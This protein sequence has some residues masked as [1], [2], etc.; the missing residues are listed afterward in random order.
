MLMS[1]NARSLYDHLVRVVVP[2]KRVITYGELSQAT[3]VPLGPPETNPL[4]DALYEIF[5]FCDGRRLP[6]LSSVVVQEKSLYD[7]TRK[8]GMPGGGYLVAEAYSENLAGRRRDPGIEAWL[9][10][11]RP[12]DTETWKMR[13]MIEAHQD[14]VWDYVG[15]WPASAEE[16]GNAESLWAAQNIGD[17]VMAILEDADS[18]EHH[19]GRPFLTAY[20]IA[21]EFARRYPEE[22][23][24]I[25]YP[26]GGLGAGQRNTLAQYLAR[27]LSRKIKGGHLPEVE[28]G[29]LSNLHL[30]DISFEV[31]GGS[32]D[33]SLTGTHSQLSMFRLR[34]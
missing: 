27:S 22:A 12:S 23:A 4:V 32:I 30:Q 18:A 34:E 20:Q 33:S 14:S 24:G 13:D 8:H 29:F 26:V 1:A 2:G 21:I 19:F 28:G 17:K 16:A 11:P 10:V 3:G 5:K 7:R 6:P 15:V 9:T 25:G 31:D